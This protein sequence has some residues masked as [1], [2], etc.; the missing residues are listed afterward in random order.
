MSDHTWNIVEGDGPHQKHAPRG[1]Y[2]ALW[3]ELLLRLEVT[4]ASR[5]VDV[6]LDD[7]K[8]AHAVWV[9]LVR[10]AREMGDD[11]VSVYREGERVIVQ[12]GKNWTKRGAGSLAHIQAHRD[13][14]CGLNEENRALYAAANG[15][16]EHRRKDGE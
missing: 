1:K 12:R 3:D 9:G 4:P 2:D 6:L 11:V 15:H 10:R 8:R 14:A 7:K 5:S 16:G 13:D